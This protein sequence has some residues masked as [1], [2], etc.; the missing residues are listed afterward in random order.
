[1]CSERCSTIIEAQGCGVVHKEVDKAVDDN[2]AWSCRG[3][4]EVALHDNVFM[5]LYLSLTTRAAQRGVGEEALAVLTNGGM[6]CG[7]VSKMG[8]QS[9]GE[10]YRG[11]P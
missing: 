10:P 3:V 11:E 9:I 8:T 6:A 1:M 5:S 2:V 4:I 7:H